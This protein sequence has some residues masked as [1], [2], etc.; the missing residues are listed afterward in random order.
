M[1]IRETCRIHA[2]DKMVAG[3][4]LP[5][6]AKVL[7]VGCG[8]GRWWSFLNT[9]GRMR[10][11]GIDI[12]TS[13]VSKAQ[14]VIR[15]FV[16]DITQVQNDIDIGNNYNLIVGNC[17][18]EHIPDIN[19]ALKNINHCLGPDGYFLL[20]LPT[21]WW[22]MNGQSQKVLN[23]I[24]P[25]LSMMFSG[26]INGFF[27]HW[28]LYGDS[29]WRYLL[30]S[31]G[32]QVIKCRGLGTPQLEFLFRLFLPSAFISF[33][34]KSLTGSYLNR[35]LSFLVPA[36]IQHKIAFSLNQLI[37]NCVVREDDRAAFEF[38]FLVKKS[39]SSNVV[40]EDNNVRV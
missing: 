3:L 22:A 35:Y 8:D 14:K 18:L 13:E 16:K 12:N 38:V 1:V 4:D 30:Q 40:N 17:S 10:V 7:D 2:F 20:F 26:M 25:R 37:Q 31:N 32:F 34:V 29:V 6:N 39:N 21:P 28:H 27:Q 36:F 23:K 19:A 9:D 11:T 5:H 24:S 15:A 33:L